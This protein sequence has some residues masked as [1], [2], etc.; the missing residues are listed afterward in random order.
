M[1]MILACGF[2][3]GVLFLIGGAAIQGYNLNRSLDREIHAKGKK[4]GF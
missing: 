1:D 4:K 2:S 3:L